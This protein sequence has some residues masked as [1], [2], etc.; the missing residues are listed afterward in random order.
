MIGTQLDNGFLW[1][2]IISGILFLIGAF[3]FPRG[4]LKARASERDQQK[5][6]ETALRGSFSARERI[7]AGRNFEKEQSWYWGAA[8]AGLGCLVVSIL[9]LAVILFPYVSMDYNLYKPYSGTVKS[10]G[11]RFLGDGKSTTENFAIQFENGDIRRVDDTRASI[12]KKGDQVTI[13]CEPQFQW[14]GTSGYVCVWG[15][16][17]LNNTN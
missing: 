11:T 16:L 7:I 1:G 6:S 2:V 17:G 10:V 15:K 12:L 3:L 13:L 5:L 14:N 8:V 4:V 9:S